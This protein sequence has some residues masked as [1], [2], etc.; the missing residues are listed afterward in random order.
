M[1]AHFSI[2]AE[3]ERDLISIR[4]GGFFG[5]DDIG[6]FVKARREAHAQLRCP[7]NAHVTINDL[8]EM[9]I[10]S[11]DIVDA[12]QGMLSKRDIYRSRR[13]AFVVSPTL[14]RTQLM[15]ALTSRNARCFE[16]R[17]EAE[18]WLFAEEADAA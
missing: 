9:K 16:S 13:L 14:A 1:S 12:F 10:Q 18:R 8:R 5:L 7:P 11:Q 6:A 3:P 4:M 2:D 17:A 15:R